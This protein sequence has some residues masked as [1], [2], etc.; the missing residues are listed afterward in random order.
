MSDWTT[1]AVD[2]IERVVTTV[3]SKTVIPA[4]NATRAIVFG[5]LTSPR[6]SWP[7]P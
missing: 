7:P 1:D 4:Q 2:N 3:R 5:L 6:S